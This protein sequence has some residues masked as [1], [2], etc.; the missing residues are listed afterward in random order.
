MD[1]GRKGPW[2]FYV[3]D[4][5]H[6]QFKAAYGDNLKTVLSG[7]PH[8]FEVTSLGG[9][10]GPLRRGPWRAQASHARKRTK[11]RPRKERQKKDTI[12]PK[13]KVILTPVYDMSLGRHQAR[14]AGTA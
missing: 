14:L 1:K 13:E 3:D 10:E 4:D 12:R 5:A 7:I 6:N 8:E 9:P 11:R 2:I